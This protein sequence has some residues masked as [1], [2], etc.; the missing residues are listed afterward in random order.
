[1]YDNTHGQTY[2]TVQSDTYDQTYMTEQSDTY[3]QTTGHKW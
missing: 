3:D 1:M 2:T